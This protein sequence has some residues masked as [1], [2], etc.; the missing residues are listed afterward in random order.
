M[1]RIFLWILALFCTG[2]AI[3]QAR[4][5]FAAIP[6]SLKKN[7]SVVIRERTTVFEVKAAD[8]AT[9][10][11]HRVATVLNKDGEDELLFYE[12]SDKFQRLE[13]A[14]IILYDAAGAVL[15]KFKKK[16]LTVDNSGEGLIEE[17]KVYYRNLA[18]RSYPVTVEYK[19][20]ISYNGLLDY[21]DFE[22]QSAEYAV[23]QSTLIVKVPG[24]L[25]LRYKN[26]YTKAEPTISI[27]NNIIVHQWQFNQLKAIKFESGSVG[28]RSRY[29]KILLAPNKFELDGNP[30]EMSSWKSFGDWYRQLGAQTLNLTEDRKAFFKAMVQDT[31]DEKAKIKKIY[32]YLQTNFRYVS[33]QLGIGGFKPFEAAFVDK[34]KYGDC[35]ALTNYTQACLDAVGI[36]SYAALINAG[37]GEAPV[38]ADFPHNGFN[39]VILCVPQGKDSI[40]LECTS[41]T[42]AFGVLSGFTENRNALLITPEGG[43]LVPTPKSKATDNIFESYSKIELNEDAGG[44]ATVRLRTIGEYKESLFEGGLNGTQDE[45]KKYL[46]QQLGF[47]QPDAFSLTSDKAAG[48]ATFD[49]VFEKIPEFTAGSKMFLNPRLY[50]IAIGNLP[51]DDNRTQDYYFSY[52]FIKTD[53]SVYVLPEGYTVDN[54]PKPIQEKFEYGEFTTSYTFDEQAGAITTTLRFVLTT[55]RIPAAK[56]LAAKLFINEFIKEYTEKMVIRRK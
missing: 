7:A 54:L 33:I 30:G 4:Y 48:T 32:D 53:T 18:T 40:W 39:H 25:G 38:E 28:R 44:K 3:A 6:D 26:R 10:T 22:I 8:K 16:D 23:E 9:F 34:K 27:P 1:P 5:P 49:L 11:E 47:I 19:Y 20:E 51:N 2:T 13:S 42:N 37:Y 35:K 50:S 52:P 15:N 14:E 55:Q 46:V 56:F 21:P 31:P 43:V 17:G 24:A 12:F 41:R 36:K 29:P 45:K